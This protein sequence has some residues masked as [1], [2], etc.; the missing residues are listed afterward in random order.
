MSRV[1]A[2]V[3]LI[4]LL[5]L[6][7]TAGA[8]SPVSSEV[9][10]F[11]PPLD[12]YHDQDL[13]GIAAVL[14]HRIV[15]QPFNLVA[16]LIFLVAILHTFLAGRITDLSHR[17]GEAHQ[18]KIRQGEARRGS[19]SMLGELFHFLG[20]V[21]VVFG[22]WALVLMGAIVAF[23]DWGTVVYY[24]GEKV[25]F[26]EA[27][28]V[29]VI[30]TLASTR[31]ILRLAESLM[32]NIAEF[33]GGS[34]RA[35]W[36][37]TLTLGPLLGSVIT[38]PAA[39]TVSAL[40][41][42]QVVY[43]LE[44]STRLKYAT[45]AL[46][47]LNVSVGGTLTNFAAPPVLMVAGP[48]GWD[49]AHMFTN[50]GWKAVIGILLV[51]TLYLLYFRK[52]FQTLQDAFG[53]R[54]LKQKIEKRYVTREQ[55]E[56]EFE[57]IKTDVQ[58]VGQL[59]AQ[60]EALASEIRARMEAE[61]LPALEREGIDPKLIREAFDKRFEEVKLTQLQR[62]VPVMLPESQQPEFQDPAWDARED[63]VPLWVTVVHLLFM[64]WTI[65]NVHHAQLFVFGM[66][67]FLGFAIITAPYQNVIRLR[68]AMLVGFFLGGLVIH[69]GLQ[70][71]WIAPVLGGLEALPLMIVAGTLSAFN[72]NASITY[73][74]TLVPGFTETLKYA[75]LAGAV[76]GGGLTIIAN[77][78]NP[79]GMSLLKHHFGGNVSPVGL[80]AWV[81][82]P[83]LI[84]GTCFMVL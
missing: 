82:I 69:G 78:P 12:S 33:F 52:E 83:T 53:L 71:W 18:E 70:A 50:F 1:A 5:T 2:I 65:V 75:V 68:S 19:I 79:A 15:A 38:E 47:F 42:S 16:S 8:S 84:M 44:P 62:E 3:S 55:M 21:E 63:P 37:T 64:V 27:A 10:S 13:D 51:N 77:A 35:M 81:L 14:G 59:A 32:E 57:R 66:L 41:L 61:T 29:V 28:F 36:M 6:A 25:D 30:M 9:A 80:F 11:P 56:T 74:S 17:L 20:E 73:L 54:K 45:L 43:V 72:D 23:F 22:L 67:L 26:T 4:I 40:V 34:L 46:L 24:V 49:T 58:A 7:A 39:M 76:T 60:T 31:P 48:W